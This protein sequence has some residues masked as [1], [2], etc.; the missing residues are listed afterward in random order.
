MLKDINKTNRMYAKIFSY[1]S[2]SIALTIFVVSTALY[3]NFENI[4]L[5]IIHS[6]VK[7]TLTQISYSAT[8]MTDSA[9]TLTTQIYFDPDVSTLFYPYPSDENDTKRSLRR[10][11]T[12]NASTPFVYSI[13]VY[14][15]DT[16][17]FYTDT[18]HIRE[19]N[20]ESFPD[21]W[22]KDTLENPRTYKT[23]VPIAR[24]I[25]PPYAQEGDTNYSYVYTYILTSSP[26]EVSKAENAIILNIS[27]AW[28]KKVTD[29]LDVNPGSNTFIIDSDGTVMSSNKKYKMLTNI[30]SESYIGNILKANKP[31][32]YFVETVGSEKMLVTY[33]S[34]NSID[35]IFVRLTPYNLIS[36][37]INTMKNTTL[38]IGCIILIGG[39]AISYLLSRRIYSPISGILSRLR[40]L[41]EE[42]R[43]N[44]YPLKQEFLKSLLQEKHEYEKEFIQKKFKEFNINLHV[45]S[46]FQLLFLK[47]DHYTDFS[48]KYNIKD[49]SLMRYAILNIACELCSPKY[50][51]EGIDMGEDHVVLLLNSPSLLSNE[52][53]QEMN[54]LVKSIQTLVR[55]YLELDLS[56]AVSTAAK[57]VDEA[58]YQY[59][60]A[61]EMSRYFVF[62]GYSCIVHPDTLD[63]ARMN[64]Y[65]Y[66]LNKE[67]LL[68]H[69][70][71]TEKAAEVKKYYL[72]I[73]DEAKGYTYATF[74]LTL[75]RMAVAINMAADSI[76]KNSGFSAS[77]DFTGFI[78]KIHTLE[79]I[80]EI[81][82][83]FFNLFDLMV[84]K[85]ED[86]KSPK[87]DELIGRIYEI[88]ESNYTSSNLSREMIAEQVGLSSVY[89]GR[90]FLKL[91]SRT[92]VDHINEFRLKKAKELLAATSSPVSDIA[93]QVGFTSA[94]YF[95]ALFKKVHG[96]TPSEYR[97][98]AVKGNP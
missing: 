41:E 23:L 57:S 80:N 5:S 64:E 34:S 91:T 2:I 81:Q 14:N 9:K 75:M 11:G 40:S 85:L 7:D 43:N 74:N 24:K 12:F 52:S 89:L 50:A 20:W 87:H 17:T 32:G 22:I 92:I 13:Y 54:D 59:G 15:K 48:N 30:S 19:Y 16:S 18:T 58:R 94:N 33:V 1:I 71:M 98:N 29:S 95:H 51:N 96:V 69:A 70:L 56:A 63:H 27:E 10:L 28:M 26:G 3:I 39:L 68:I 8:F 4:G 86:R 76:E 53:R 38:F 82:Q 66:P 6:F 36:G 35:W 67:K 84:Q 46:S 21:P 55:N 37:K 77:Y 60:E 93:V 45:S 73:I 88:V 31:S 83:H 97:Q 44:F 25:L 79:T 90:L 78:A 49:R 47:I 65:N 61:I 62:Y 42:K 72:E